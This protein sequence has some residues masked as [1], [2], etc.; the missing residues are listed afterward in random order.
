[1]FDAMTGQLFTNQGTGEFIVGGVPDVVTALSDGVLNS[2][3]F[4]NGWKTGRGSYTQYS[5]YLQVNSYSSGSWIATNDKINSLLNEYRY[6]V[7]E[8]Q[9]SSYG[10]NTAYGAVALSNGNTPAYSFATTTAKHKIFIDTSS[11]TPSSV[12]YFL[13]VGC[14]NNISDKIYNIWFSNTPYI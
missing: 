3:L 12:D 10:N 4:P 6:I 5:G 2:Q 7:F 14:G 13:S 1:M 8:I 9:P 11:L